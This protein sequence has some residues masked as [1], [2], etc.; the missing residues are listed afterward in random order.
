MYQYRLYGLN[1]SSSRKIKLL[2]EHTFSQTD[3]VVEWVLSNG[4][5]PNNTF[6]WKPIDTEFLDKIDY[7]SLWEAETQE[8]KFT[9]VCF[10][11]EERQ[12]LNF[13]LD[14]NKEKLWVYHREDEPEGD[15]DSYFVGPVLGFTMRM[16]E[17]ICLHSSVVGIE[18]KAVLFL[19]HSTAGKSTIAAGMAD[20]EAEILADDVAVLSPE[21]DGFQSTIGIFKSQT[22]PKSRRIFN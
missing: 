7:I 18:G 11:K 17:T 14:S 16:R 1:I 8:G 22:P 3:L 9:K 6:E 10:E 13:V 19:G 5:T 4:E 21:N 2:T 20:A 15:L 12:H